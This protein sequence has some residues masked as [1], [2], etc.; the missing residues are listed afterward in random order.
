[1]IYFQAL[2]ATAAAGATGYDAGLRSTA[3]N[4]K[5]LLSVLVQVQEEPRAAGSMLQ[6][7][8]EQEKVAEIPT[9]L[10]DSC[11]ELG[12]VQ[13]SVNRLNEVEV[14]FDIP[15][16]AIVRLAVK[17]VDFEQTIIGAYRYEITGA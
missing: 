8:Y 2:S 3:E 15:I 12:V 4:P 10:L 6:L 13:W 1:M 5:R 14:G 9:R 16:G 17:A 11:D 7:W